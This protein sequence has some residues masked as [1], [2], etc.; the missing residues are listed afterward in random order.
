ME[1]KDKHART[2]S[3]SRALLA[4]VICGLIAALV[5]VIYDF[6]YRRI[7]D[8]HIDKLISPFP[9]FIGFPLMMA[10]A[11]IIF[12]ILVE[13]LKQGKLVFTIIFFLATLVA[14]A[15]DIFGPNVSSQMTGL[16]LGMII[17][18]GI[19]IA[20]LLPYLATHPGIFMEQEELKESSA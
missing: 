13:Y 20:F 5:N 3:F 11:G 12:W 10:I 7:A 14:L 18:S 4:G 15:F 2:T 17:V 8:F 16:L 6:V 1:I 19:L 9:I